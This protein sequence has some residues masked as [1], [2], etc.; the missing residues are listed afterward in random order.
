MN[1]L[2]IVELKL[3]V[4]VIVRVFAQLLAKL[5]VKLVYWFY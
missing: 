3:L 2:V 5:M 4:L 1:L